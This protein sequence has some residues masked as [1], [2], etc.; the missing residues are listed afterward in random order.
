MW[1]L[2]LFLFIK[3]LSLS[4]PKKIFYLW[5]LIFLLAE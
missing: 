3:M 5:D 2:F 1:Q 4:F